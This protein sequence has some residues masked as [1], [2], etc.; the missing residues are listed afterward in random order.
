MTAISKRLA[1]ALAVCGAASPALAE[2]Q[3][4]GGELVVLGRD[5]L[6]GELRTRYDAALAM[7]HDP[8]IVAADDTRYL[9]ASE[10]KVQ[11]GIALGYLRSGHKDP[12]SIGKCVNAA[13]WMNHQPA[14]PAPM[15]ASGPSTVTPEI[16][17]QSIAGTVF[18]DWDS[19]VPN[20]DAG[21]TVAYVANTLQACGRAGLD[22]TGHADR[23]GPDSHNDPLSL[24]R[25]N[26]V[27]GMLTSAGVPAA[28]LT[29][30]GRGEHQPRVPTADGVRDPQNRR[31]E[32]TAK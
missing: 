13:V 21:Q 32:I 19:A 3:N 17:R 29:I 27:A 15:P 5:Q 26:A 12:I 23:S 22:V 6:H 7:T 8:A 25:A 10:A 9:W 30:G 4:G 24:R 16:C 28:I 2:A 31:V 18:F 1:L 20:A 14:P 11:C